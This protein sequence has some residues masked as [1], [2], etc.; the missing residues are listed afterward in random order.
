MTLDTCPIVGILPIEDDVNASE[1]CSG[2]RRDGEDEEQ[3]EA[4]GR[5]E[6]SKWQ[7]FVVP[8]PVVAAADTGQGEA[9]NGQYKA[10][11]RGSS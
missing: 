1:D 10:D 4:V 8:D 9:E 3:E 2:P 6:D 5:A 7:V 11:H